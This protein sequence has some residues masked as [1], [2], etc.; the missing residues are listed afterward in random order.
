MQGLGAIRRMGAKFARAAGLQGRAEQVLVHGRALAAQGRYLE[1][2]EYATAEIQSLPDAAI[3]RQ[4]AIWRHQA[5]ATIPHPPGRA[6]WPPK[7]VDPF[8]TVPGIPEIL[9]AQAVTGERLGGAILHHGALIVR[10]LL[11]SQEAGS[12]VGGIDRAFAAK[13]RFTKGVTDTDDAS[14]YERLPLGA[15]SW[16][17]YSRAFAEE[18]DSILTADS[19]RNLANVVAMIRAKGIDDA[20]ADYLGEHPAISIGKS[21]LRCVPPH[22][23]SRDWHQDG[24]FLGESVRTVN[25]WLCLSHCGEDASGLGM[26]PRRLPRI[27]ETGTRGAEYDW[28]VGHD[29]AVELA[30]GLAIDSPIFQPGDAVFFDGLF[31]HR[32]EGR[33]GL[34]K[35]R[36]AIETWFFAPSTYPMKW[37]PLVV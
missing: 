30:D 1:A 11:T 35:A 22:E 18:H 25:F 24:A 5:F 13:S 28:S 26:V 37:E 27:V 20:V 8:P 15:T 32:T 9:G 12:F 34:T 16:N 2:I 21:T 36:Y 6:E 17:H 23:H 29:L 10:G 33:P 31:L 14:W 7:I 4:I 3:E 19:P